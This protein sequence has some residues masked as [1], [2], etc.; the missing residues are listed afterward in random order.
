[1]SDPVTFGL[2]HGACHGSW[3]W[4]PLLRELD[5][6]GHRSITVDLPITDPTLGLLEYA[7]CAAAAF[8]DAPGLVLVGHSLGGYV[9][10]FVA[11]LIPVR[12][13]VFLTAAIQEGAFAGLPSASS[14]LLIPPEEM[15]VDDT[16]LI[17]LSNAAA[18]KYFYH[19]VSESM[20]A[21]AL[22][23][24]RPQGV[25]SLIPGRLPQLDPGVA[26]AAIVCT[27]DRAISPEWMRAAARDGLQCVPYELPGSHSPFLTRPAELAAILD[28]IV[29]DRPR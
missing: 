20:T 15:P 6:L 19:D 24:L 4:G 14:M 2:V 11:E 1:M 3:Q 16:G 22:A 9:I 8:A 21:W 28:D 17:R 5:A 10:P 18:Q 12:T 25:G 13:V 7:A 29:S 23:Q 27:D 26:L